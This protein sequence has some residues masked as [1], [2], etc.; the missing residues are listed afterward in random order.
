[1]VRGGHKEQGGGGG[2]DSGVEQREDGDD[3]SIGP[4]LDGV[5]GL[6]DPYSMRTK[7]V[8]DTE[9]RTQQNQQFSGA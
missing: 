9:T 7:L 5:D 1:M 3:D 6:S 4:V 2:K 8:G